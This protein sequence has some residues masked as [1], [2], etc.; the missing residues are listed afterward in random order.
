LTHIKTFAGFYDNPSHREWKWQKGTRTFYE[1]TV[2]HSN[3]VKNFGYSFSFKKFNDDSYRKDDFKKRLLGYAKLDYIISPLSS[4][5][6]L[7]NYLYMNRGN[8]LY[9]KDSRNILI[10]KEEDQNKTVESNRWFLSLI[11]KQGLSDKISA[12]LKASYYYSKFDGK[13]IEITSSKA[14]L[15]R[16]E[17]LIN[18]KLMNNFILIS[19]IEVSYAEINS[20]LFSSPH[21]FTAAGYAQAEYKGIK[22]LVATIGLRYDHIKLDTLLGAD[23]YAPKIGL[24]YSFSENLVWRGSFGTGFRAP[25]PA[26]VFTT[27]DL[28]M[29]IKIKENLELEAETSV[30]FETGLKYIP[31]GYINLDIALFYTTYDNFIEPELTANNEIQLVNIVEANIEGFELVTNFSIIP[32]ELQLSSGYTYL[33]AR[34]TRLNKALKYRPRHLLYLNLEYK[35]APFEF[36]IDFRYWSKVEEIDF[37]IVELGLVKDGELRVPGYV[38][39]FRAGY[40]FTIGSSLLNY[41]YVEAVGNLRPIRNFALGINLFL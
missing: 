10:Q 7:T 9:W 20:N 27:S 16:N 39:D 31:S 40:N 8:F 29:G 11:Y 23:A 14:D 2:T 5:S 34:N 30:S 41:N 1:T 12:E 3:S 4:V 13:G 37:R 25:T 22:N 24:N 21:F 17:L 33:W 26:E 6:F 38:L 35:P 28:G 15:L 18:F 19:G 32:D 36:R